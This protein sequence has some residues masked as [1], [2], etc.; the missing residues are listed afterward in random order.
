M[1]RPALFTIHES[2]LAHNLQQ[3]RER[4]G[5]S[6]IWAVCK[7]RGYGLGLDSCLR[8]FANAD[9]LAVLELNEAQQLRDGGWQGPLMLLEGAFSKAETRD[10]LELGCDVVV[11]QPD[12]LSWLSAQSSLLERG[13]SRIW[14]KFNTGMHR[15]GFSVVSASQRAQ[16]VQTAQA[17]RAL[18]PAN[19]RGWMTHFACADETDGVTAPLA[20]WESLMRAIDP[21]AGE[22]QSLANSAA[23]LLH[24]QTHAQWVRPGIMLYGASPAPG[25]R[26]AADWSLAPAASLTSELISV[27]TVL[28]GESI[29]YGGCFRAQAEMRIGVVAMGYADGYLRQAP[30]GTPVLVHGVRCPLVGRVSMDMITVDVTA[31]P[32]ARLGSPVTL[33]GQGLPI[34]EVAQ[35]CGTNAYELYTGVTARVARRLEPYLAGED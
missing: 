14:M 32:A 6:L 29:G 7:A 16:A 17:L 31:C 1:S 3:V 33:W 13:S 26:S 9:G 5:S 24:A 30:D 22:Q 35:S 23:V 2:A 34:D 10:A 20:H 4:V 21:Q 15:L 25:Q 12:Q 8:G 19:R 28:A 18:V 11:H 27:Q